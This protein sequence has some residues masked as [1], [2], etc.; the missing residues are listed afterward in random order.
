M[1]GIVEFKSRH[2]R[3]PGDL[4]AVSFWGRGFPK[5]RVDHVLG[6]SFRSIDGSLREFSENEINVLKHCLE[7]FSSLSSLAFSDR[8]CP[9]N[10]LRVIENLTN[11]TTLMIFNS[12]LQDEDLV[13]LRSLRKLNYFLIRQSDIGSDGLAHVGE[14]EELSKLDI[15]FNL[16]ITTIALA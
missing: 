1:G 16:N 14:L 3:S 9:P 8:K 12:P 5:K 6:V 2:V 7:S 4:E 15:C 13:Y 11:L 10:G